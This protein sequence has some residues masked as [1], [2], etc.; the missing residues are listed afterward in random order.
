MSTSTQSRGAVQFE[1]VDATFD[2][3]FLAGLRQFIHQFED[4]FQDKRLYRV[5]GQLLK[6]VIAAGVPILSCYLTDY[7]DAFSPCNLLQFFQ[8]KPREIM[9]IQVSS[10]CHLTSVEKSKLH[11]DTRS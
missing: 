11:R 7:H 5:F 2:T 10:L 6:G 3:L 1:P 9:K 4:I 8:P